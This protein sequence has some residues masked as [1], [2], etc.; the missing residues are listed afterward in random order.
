VEQ[1]L[2]DYVWIDGIHLRIRLDEARPP[3]WS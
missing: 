3:S 1:F 2:T